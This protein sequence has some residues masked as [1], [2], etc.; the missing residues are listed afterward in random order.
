MADIP[1]PASPGDDAP[2]LLVVDDDTRIRNLL[3]QY[4][5]E[6]GFRRGRG[7]AMR[8]RRAG[9]LEGLDFDLLVLDVMMPGETG[10][11]LDQVAAG[12]EVGA[13]PDADG[14]VGDR[15]P[16]RRTGSRR[17]R[18]PAKAVRPARAHPAHQQHPAPRRPFRYAE[19]RATG[20]RPLHLPDRRARTE[21]AAASRS[22]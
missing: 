14:A 17:R 20:V 9:K 15:Q 6:N 18:L 3:K 8:T 7:R 11:D 1:S 4:L 13:D 21:E 12:A 5:T 16:H 10:V 2:H 19:G 22:S